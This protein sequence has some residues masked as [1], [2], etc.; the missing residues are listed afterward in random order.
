MLGLGRLTW[1]VKDI[2][3]DNVYNGIVYSWVMMGMITYV[4]FSVSIMMELLEE[5]KQ[6]N[7]LWDSYWF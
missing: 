3:Q 5:R 2:L 4:C 7:I 1:Q 6:D